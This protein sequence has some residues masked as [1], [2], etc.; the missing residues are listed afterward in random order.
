MPLKVLAFGTYDLLHP[1]HEHHLRNAK[2]LGDELWVV[3]A[4]DDTV[5]KVKGR[6]PHNDERERMAALQ[7]LQYVDHVLLGRPGDKYVVIEEIVPDIIVLG[8]DQMTFTDA[9]ASELAA[10]GLNPKIVR[11]TKGLEPETYKSSKMRPS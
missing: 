1:G 8:Y 3:V 9:L 6:L 2:A 11:F 7:A 4:R 10:R 5:E